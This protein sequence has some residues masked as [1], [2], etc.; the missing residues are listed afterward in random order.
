MVQEAELGQTRLGLVSA[1]VGISFV[2]SPLQNLSAKRVVYRP[3]SD[4]FPT[5]KLAL[6]WRQNESSPVVHE[7]I[8]VLKNSIVNK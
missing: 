7:F 3:L 4:N 2:L 1:G 8:K 5:L 6:T